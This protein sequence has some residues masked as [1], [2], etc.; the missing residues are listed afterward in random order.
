MAKTSFLH[1]LPAMG[2]GLVDMAVETADMGYM[3]QK[4]MKSLED[5][6]LG[7][8]TLVCA[9]LCTDYAML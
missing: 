2:D 3:L 6:H 1:L 8:D 4:H 5:Q 9:F 7:Y